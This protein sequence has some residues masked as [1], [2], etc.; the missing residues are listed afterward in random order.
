MSVSIVMSVFNK[1][2]F[3]KKTINSVLSQSHEDFEFIIVDGGSTDDSLRIINSIKDKRIKIYSQYNTGI[4]G[5][6]NFGIRVSKYELIS[7][8]DAD[9]EWNLDFLEEIILLKDSY[10][11]CKAFVTAYTKKYPRY[12]EDVVIKSKNKNGIIKDYFLK[13][14]SGWGV[15]TSSVAI[16]KKEILITGGFPVLIGSQIENKSY[17]IDINGEIIFE[18]EANLVLDKGKWVRDIEN[19]IFKPKSIKNIDSYKISVPGI[20]GEDQYLWDMIALNY[21]YAYSKKILSLWNGDVPN[22]ATTNPNE[23]PIYPHL[24]SL[25][26]NRKKNSLIISKYLNYLFQDLVFKIK[27]LNK[28]DFIILLKLHHYFEWNKFIKKEFNSNIIKLIV[29]LNNYLFRF[30]NKLIK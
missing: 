9:D 17:V 27:K 23:L 20:P 4:A 5:A 28:E 22:Q 19:L 11:D 7:F 3:L 2:L 15:H 30:K 8:I 21:K 10:K 24:I 26:Q 16:Y 6:R 1:A 18:V 29:I 13:R 25:Y 12:D 14:I